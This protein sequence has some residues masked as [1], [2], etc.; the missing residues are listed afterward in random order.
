MRKAGFICCIALALSSSGLAN[1][2]GPP[3]AMTCELAGIEGCSSKTCTGSGVQDPSLTLTV[4]RTS[5]TLAIN[6]IVGRIDDS[7]SDPYAEGFHTVTWNWDLISYKGYRMYE[8]S[9]SLL[10][11]LTENGSNLVF[12]CLNL[13]DAKP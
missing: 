6:G 13:L 9:N 1:P 8:A 5:H 12:N 7:E 4:S 10:I 11:G 2:G 3:P